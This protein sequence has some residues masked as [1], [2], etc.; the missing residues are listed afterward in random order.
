MT[1]R[2]FVD[3][4]GQEL[5]VAHLG[6]GVR[7]V[8]PPG[9]VIFDSLSV[10]EAIARQFRLTS[11]ELRSDSKRHRFTEARAAGYWLLWHHSRMTS[12]EIAQ[13]FG[14]KDHT[15]VLFGI[16]RCEK[17]R[18]SDTW[19]AAALVELQRELE[20]KAVAA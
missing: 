14:K 19:F 5:P 9:T 8:L 3:F 17:R 15:T 10:F 6:H 7:R 13:V 20:A 1:D 16:K 4:P 2:P 12:A 18:A 11:N